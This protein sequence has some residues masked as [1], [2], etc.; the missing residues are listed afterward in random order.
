M[1][2][3]KRNQFTNKDQ[4]CVSAVEG[5]DMSTVNLLPSLTICCRAG[6]KSLPRVMVKSQAGKGSEESI[7]ERHDA[8]QI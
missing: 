1:G 3:Q 5:R 4:A 8:V 2:C 7:S 6:L